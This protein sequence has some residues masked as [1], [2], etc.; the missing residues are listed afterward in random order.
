[1]PEMYEQGGIMK[2][3]TAIYLMINT[4]TDCKSKEIDIRYTLFFVILICALKIYGRETM[5]WSG[6]IPGMILF[7]VSVWKK[8]SLGS[9]DGIVVSALGWALGI[10]KVWSILVNGFLFAGVVGVFMWFRKKETEI[11]FVTFLMAGY[12]LEEWGKWYV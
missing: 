3:M 1:M 10:E 5:Y 4:W 12:I 7:I 6:M 9:G 11:P 2:Y 8:S